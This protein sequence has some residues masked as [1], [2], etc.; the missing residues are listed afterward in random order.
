MS[1]TRKKWTA[2]SDVTSEILRLREKKKWQI[3]L[4]RYVVEKLGSAVYAQ[5]F[6]L[7]ISNFR[8]WIE[9][10][11]KLGYSW[12]NFGVAWQFDH[13]IPVSHFDF[14]QQ[15]DLKLCWN[16]LNIRALDLEIGKKA[17]NHFDLG[18]ARAYFEGLYDRTSFRPCLY[19]LKK[20][21]K[22]ER[23][24][25]IDNE[26]QVDFLKAKREYLGQIAQFGSFEFGLLNSGLE[27]QDVIKASSTIRKDPQRPN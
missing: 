24:E 14:R 18:G 2:H 13:I 10:Q 11:F 12:E 20:L 6:G 26:R 7:D 25:M 23:S 17:T 3:A 5:Y 27:I 1:T 9:S 15:E 22:I 19:F 16:F 8:A 21:D 4:R